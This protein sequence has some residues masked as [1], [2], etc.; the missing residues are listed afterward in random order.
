MKLNSPFRFVFLIAAVLLVASV[1]IIYLV[2]LKTLSN[3]RQVAS[4][5]AI[6][7][8]LETSLSTLKDAETGERGYLLTGN[9]KYLEPYRQALTQERSEQKSLE[10]LSLTGDLPEEEVTRINRLTQEKL[11][12]LEQ[13]ILLRKTGGLEAALAV[14]RT[15]AGKATMNEIR[16]EISQLTVAHESKLRYALQGADAAVTL[17]TAAF[18]LMTLLDLGILLWAY[19]RVGRE[20]RAHGAVA[21]ELRR[22]KEL[23]STTLASIG[24]GVIVTDSAGRVTSINR[25]AERLTGWPIADATGRPMLEVFSIVNEQ[26]RQPAE[27]PVEKVFRTGKVVGLANHT[28]LIARDGTEMPIDDSA[29]PIRMA[30]GS[31][32]GVVLVFRDFTQQRTAQLLRARLAANRG[33]V[34]DPGP[35]WIRFSGRQGELLLLSP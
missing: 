1:I 16:S 2:G 35:S 25:E 28:T 6:L 4:E 11:A 34:I 7:R 15:D 19:K 21:V 13:T 5:R 24:D 27:N 18:G 26:T 8:H 9:E 29:A 20:I 31:L 33:L 3:H 12:E 17:R 22:E 23:M 14:V 10:Q 30:D 32:S